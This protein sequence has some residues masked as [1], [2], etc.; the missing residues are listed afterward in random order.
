MDYQTLYYKLKTLIKNGALSDP[1]LGITLRKHRYTSAGACIL[2]GKPFYYCARHQCIFNEAP[3]QENEYPLHPLRIPDIAIDENKYF[4]YTVMHPAGEKSSKGVIF[5]FHGLNEK[6]WDKYMPWA[7]RLVALTGKSVVLFPIAFHMERAPHGWSDLKAMQKVVVVRQQKHP[8]FSNISYVNTAISIRLA[9]Q[10]DRLFWS[11]LQTYLDITRLIRKIK[12][13]LVPGISAS[14][15][16][17]FFGYSIGAFLALILKMANP[18]DYFKDTRLFAFCGGVT[19]DR[20]FPISKYILDS[21]G[22][23]AL[24]SYFSE[25]LHNHFKASPRLAHYM[26]IHEGENYFKFMLHFNHYKKEREKIIADIHQNIMAVPLK[27]D[28]VIPPVEVLST[29]QGDY[30]DIPTKVIPMDFPFPYDHVHPFSLMDKY[31]QS[32]DQ[33]FTEVMQ[34][35]ASFLANR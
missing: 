8:G 31:R 16:F 14:A 21:N 15:S 6:S 34:A 26:Q 35:A 4:D 1:E 5:M 9:S 23:H 3:G 7:A 24:N 2:P 20:T 32:T 11:G 30:R 18:D 10:P 28:R 12:K 25:Q 19:L 22:G 27:K 29:L 33:A 13:G 17:D